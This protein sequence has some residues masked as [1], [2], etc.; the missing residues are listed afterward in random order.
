[1]HPW[2]HKEML[3]G[4]RGCRAVCRMSQAGAQRTLNIVSGRAT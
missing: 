4:S 1:M 2:A 3:E